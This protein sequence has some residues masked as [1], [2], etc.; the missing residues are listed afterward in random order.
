MSL[1]KKQTVHD[2]LL[3]KNVKLEELTAQAEAASDL[4]TRTIS[5]LELVNQEIDDTVAEIDE[6]T[7]K[8]SQTRSALSRNRR[9]NAAVIN[10]FSKLLYVDEE[11]ENVSEEVST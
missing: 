11:D 1:F 10:N 8:L 6:Y 3:E 5:G 4:V 2:I 9:R 7:K